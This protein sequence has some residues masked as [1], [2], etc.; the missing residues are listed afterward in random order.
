VPPLQ[1]PPFSHF[2]ALLV[3]QQLPSTRFSGSVQNDK[4]YE[5]RKHLISLPANAPLLIADSKSKRRS[6]APPLP[7][8]FP[9]SSSISLFAFYLRA[10]AL[11]IKVIEVRAC[12]RVRD[13]CVRTM[14][15]YARTKCQPL[16]FPLSPPPLAC[17]FIERRL[18]TASS[19]TAINFRGR[20][21]FSAPR[22]PTVASTARLPFRLGDSSA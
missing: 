13:N 12:D 10:N 20:E 8:L 19:L 1:F 18:F 5:R 4:C 3:W 17:V 2:F 9:P 15:I 16:P 11:R 21:I 22:G 14:R 7:S 6:L